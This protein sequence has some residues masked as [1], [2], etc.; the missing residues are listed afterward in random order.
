MLSIQSNQIYLIQFFPIHSTQSN[1]IQFLQS[2]ITIPLF[3]P[4]TVIDDCKQTYLVVRPRL[5]VVSADRTYPP[6]PP[7][8]TPTGPHLKHKT[9]TYQGQTLMSKAEVKRQGQTS[10]SNTKVKDKVKGQG[11]TLKSKAKI[12]RQGQMLK[13]SDKVKH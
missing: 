1:S 10:W 3:T 11:Q 5:P 6:Y 13:S 7:R 12:K 8:Q 9:S 4:I 2:V